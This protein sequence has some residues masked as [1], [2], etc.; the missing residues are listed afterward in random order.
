MKLVRRKA[1][2]SFIIIFILTMLVLLCMGIRYIVIA[3]ANPE[4]EGRSITDKFPKTAV[5]INVTM[6]FGSSTQRGR[7][8]FEGYRMG[9]TYYTLNNFA[10]WLGGGNNLA[11][12][13]FT[14]SNSGH[15]NAVTKLD[16]YGMKL[17]N[18]GIYPGNTDTYDVNHVRQAGGHCIINYIVPR[19][20]SF[21][22]VINNYPFASFASLTQ[23][24]VG[25]V[26]ISRDLW[27]YS[28]SV[29]VYDSASDFAGNSTSQ[30]TTA[31]VYVR[32]DLQRM[33]EGVEGELTINY[34]P[35]T[36]TINYNL[37]GG[38]V[39]NPTTYNIE[40]ASFTL[41]NPT[42]EGYRFTGW[43]GTDISGITTNAVVNT[44]NL[45]NKTYTA[46]WVQNNYNVTLNTGTGI[47][48][49]TGAG[50]YTVGQTVTINA[51]PMT[52]YLWSKWSGSYNT[53]T[54]K[55]S[56]T[57]PN[58]DVTITANAT[59]IQ[60]TVTYNGNG[61][62]GGSTGNTTHTYNR[63]NNLASNGY[64]RSYNVTYQGNG[65]TTPNSQTSNYAFYRWRQ[66]ANGT[67]NAYTSGQTNVGNLSS[68][69]GATVTLYAQWTRRSHSVTNNL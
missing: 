37:N 23:N 13:E 8:V 29:S 32:G 6:N 66:Y 41:N 16:A 59:P 4:N 48:S 68:T 40:T 45:G 15:I 3:Y 22:G 60:Y 38:T 65:G 18:Y 11:N 54:K 34:V 31:S 17:G 51:T 5:G 67:G 25:I 14:M 42:R 55:Y 36:Y 1:K 27:S 44:N 39:T 20:Y 10:I 49:V 57:M 26:G 12:G 52:G 19:G 69:N 47:A 61:A 63:T 30:D 9:T 62:T 43:S 50:S 21:S 2:N 24:G 53:T 7:V 28:D 46:N 64:T 58:N 35:T 56:F 33:M